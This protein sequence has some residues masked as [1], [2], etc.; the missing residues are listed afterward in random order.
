MPAKGFGGNEFHCRC[1]MNLK[2][3]T[4]K[5]VC[6]LLALAGISCHTHA[7][8]SLRGTVTGTGNESLTGAHVIINN[9]YYQTITNSKGEFAFSGIKPGTY[10][11]TVSFVGYESHIDSVILQGDIN[12]GIVMKESAVLS[13]AVIVSAV[14]ATQ[15][16]PT[17]YTMINKD[18]INQRNLAQDLPYLL[19]YEPSVVAFSDAGAGVGYTY[20]RVR[21]SDITRINVTINGIPLNDPESHAVYWVD[22]PDFA[23]SVN[24]IQLQRGVGSSTNGAGAFGASMNI[25]TNSFQAAPFGIISM[26]AGSF[27]TYKTTFQAGTGLLK[28]H[29]YFEGRGSAIGSDGYIDRASSKLSSYFIQGGY[30]NDKT[31]VKAIAFGGKEKTYQAWYGVDAYTMANDRTFNWAGSIFN[32]DGSIRYYDNQ[33]DNYQQNHYQL[34]FSHRLS[35]SLNINLS[36]HYTRGKGYYEE[37]LQNESFSNYGLNE[38]YFGLDSISDGSTYSYFYHDTINTTDLVRRRWLDNQ[39]YGLTWSLRYQRNKADLII[40]GALNKYDNARHFGEVIW[41]EFSSQLQNDDKY[42]N[43]TARKTDFNVFAKAAWSPTEALTIYGDLQYRTI[44]YEVKGIE[45]HL[46]DAAV[47]VSFHFVNPKA[48]ISYRTKA[49]TIYASYS[50]AHREPVRDDF[51][52]ALPGEKPKPEYLGNLELGIRKTEAGFQYALNFYL[53]NYINQLVLTGEINDN[54]AY[55]RKNAGKSYRTGIELSG[56]YRPATLVELAGNLSLS[57]NKTDYRQTGDSGR[58]ALYK[59]SDISFSPRIIAGAQLKLFPIRDLEFN[60]LFKFVGK[61]FLDN[62][63]NKDLMLNPYLVNDLRIAYLLSSARLPSVELT[64]MINNLFNVSYEPNGFV[65]GNTRYYYP[66]AGRNFLAGVTVRF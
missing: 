16:T 57:I 1:F 64:L 13:D 18:E 25:E 30:Y 62:T 32:E 12:L 17:T 7:Q 63:G 33:T 58:I 34:H 36:G 23:S 56:G 39:Y 42:Y 14:R 8:F 59:N 15:N 35:N 54:G 55:I 11:V 65:D 46:Q 29:W 52:D 3:I 20:L 40:G 28:D 6:I 38:L 66:Q 22:I 44:S 60:W 5:Q 53:M 2:N 31:L 27:N 19:S 9:T 49:G 26:S 51:I 41:A 37:Y 4:M 61:Q 10:E 45:S 21:G 47:D 50:I 24:S 43:N 48:G